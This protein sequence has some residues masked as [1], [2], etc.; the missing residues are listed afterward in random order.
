M[1]PVRLSRITCKKVVS[2][3]AVGLFLL[4]LWIFLWPASLGGST[5][6]VTVSGTSMQPGM[7]TGDLAVVRATDDY[8]VGDVVAYHPKM[9]NGEYSAVVIHRIVGGNATSGFVMQGDNNGFEDPWQPVP[10]QV[11]GELWFD[12]P[13]AGTVV[14]AMC[15]PVMAA[16]IL[17]ALTVFM[18]LIGGGS[19][20]AADARENESQDVDVGAKQ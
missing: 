7:Y 1:R 14:A 16:S 12:V 20:E 3:L 19:K 17:A 6:L 8:A 18:V 9:P 5:T 15:E 10:E 2:G 13:D 4:A 11:V